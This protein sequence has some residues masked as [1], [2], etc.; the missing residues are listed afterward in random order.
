MRVGRRASG[1]LVDVGREHT[2]PGARKRFGDGC[3]D[4]GS[5]ARY[6][7]DS[8]GE[9]EHFRAAASPAPRQEADGDGSDDGEGDEEHETAAVAARAIADRGD[10]H[11]RHRF[12]D[13]VGGQDD[14]HEASED[15]QP[16]QLRR[17]ERNDHVVAAEADAE[18]ERED[19]QLAT[20]RRERQQR[21][22]TR[23]DAR[24]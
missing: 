7:R 11:R 8:V 16:E 6:E 4:A 14:P 5:S 10:E 9:I 24:R 15:A 12:R 22:R 1:R 21:D 19:V 3:A 20:R 18:H 23:H 2:R 17:H 13:A